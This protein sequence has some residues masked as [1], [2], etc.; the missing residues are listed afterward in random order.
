M[1]KGAVKKP[2]HLQIG[3]KF[4]EESSEVLHLGQ[5]FLWC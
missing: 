2:F 5:S 1:A 4:K 3:L